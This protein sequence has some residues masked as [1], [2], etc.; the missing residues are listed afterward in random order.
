[1]AAAY[2]NGVAAQSSGQEDVH[3]ESAAHGGII[4]IPAALSLAGALESSGKEL[5]TAVVAGYEFLCRIGKGGSDPEITRRG[6]R[7]STVFGI[8]G[9]C[10]AASK[11]LG[12]SAEQ[13]IAAIGCSGEFLLRR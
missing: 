12:L 5:I 11:L 7:P 8:F 2:A 6:F 1:M 9:A 4:V 3:R 10:V 13:M